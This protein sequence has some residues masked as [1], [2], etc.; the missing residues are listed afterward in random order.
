MQ[1]NDIFATPEAAVAAGRAGNARAD[2]AELQHRTRNNLLLLEDGTWTFRYDKALRT[3]RLPRPDAGDAWAMLPKIK[4]PTLLIRGELS[5]V[6]D[7]AVAERMLKEIPDCKFAL[8]PGS[9][10]SIPLESPGRVP[11]RRSR[12]S[13]RPPGGCEMSVA[14]GGGASGGGSSANKVGALLLGGGLMAVVAIYP[15]HRLLDDDDDPVEPAP[16]SVPSG[17]GGGWVRRRPHRNLPFA[18][19]QPPAPLKQPTKSSAP[20]RTT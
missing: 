10:H 7:P 3:N 12:P 4:A 17:G 19:S 1:A 6:L 20:T 5:D 2:E 18:P 14:P 9:G 11:S 16:A 8:V 15:V 13:Y